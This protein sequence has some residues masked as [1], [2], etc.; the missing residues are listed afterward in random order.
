MSTI[1]QRGVM[2]VASAHGSS[3][4]SLLA[5]REL[6]P[7]LGGVHQAR[8][9]GEGGRGVRLGGRGEARGWGGGGRGVRLGGRGARPIQGGHDAPIGGAMDAWG[10]GEHLCKGS[11]HG[12]Q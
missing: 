5:N 2:A 7:L 11:E 9:W 6:N 1:A 12:C 10:G 4:R 3:L 8:G